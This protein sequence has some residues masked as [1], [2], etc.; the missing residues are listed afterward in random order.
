MNLIDVTRQFQTEDDA[1]QFVE[2]MR[3]PDGIV[4]CPTCGCDRIS[5]ITRKPKERTDPKKHV[6]R[7]T[8]IYQCLEKTCKQQFSATR[9]TIFGDS[10]IPVK[11]WFMA[12]AFILDAKK[13]M[14]ALQLQR[15]LG[16][17]SYESAWYLAH[18]IRKAMESEGGLLSGV[19][20]I[21]ETYIGGKTIRRKDRGTNRKY[22]SKDAVIGMIERGGRLRFEHIGKGSATARAVTPVVEANISPDVERIITDQS[23]IYPFGLPSEHKTKHFTVD[24]SREYVRLGTDIHT[25]TIESAFSLLKRGIVGSFHKVSIKHLHRYLSEFE[26]RFNE[27]KNPE[28]FELLVSRMC[29]TETMPYQ[30]LVAKPT[31]DLTYGLS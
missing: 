29:Q 22:Q 3:W 10:H 27:R 18:R 4:R 5:K 13:G 9:G 7:R 11:T 26:M 2:Q 21:D 19:V 24:H 23:A 8:R 17:K 25:N 15:H 1:L 31:N 12:I 6:N 14:S 30:H 16:L 20:E 28:K